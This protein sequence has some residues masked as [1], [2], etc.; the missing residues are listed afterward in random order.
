MPGGVVLAMRHRLNRWQQN[1]RQHNRIEQG[2]VPFDAV[3]GAIGDDL[4]DL[5]IGRMT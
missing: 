2:C 3:V 5:D 1:N 4:G